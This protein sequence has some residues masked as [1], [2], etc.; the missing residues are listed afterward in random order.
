MHSTQCHSHLKYELPDMEEIRAELSGLTP[1]A[2][3]TVVSLRFVRGLS[4]V[5]LTPE[6]IICA[7]RK[8]KNPY[9]FHPYPSN[10]VFR[11]Q[12]CWHG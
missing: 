10:T 4:D 3:W 12:I 8:K 2:C 7:H 9:L 1:L 6:H 5:F 11:R